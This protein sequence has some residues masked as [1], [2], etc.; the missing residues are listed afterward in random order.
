[1]FSTA[2][3]KVRT[4]LVFAKIAYTHETHMKDPNQ[5]MKVGTPY[6]KCPVIDVAGRQVNDSAI[7]FKNL[8]PAIGLPFNEEW[9]K[10]ITL[11]LD[12]SVKIQGQSEDWSKL[13]TATILNKGDAPF[14]S[15]LAFILVPNVV[16]PKMVKVESDQGKHNI[17]H[18]GCGHYEKPVG[19]FAK[20]FAAA[21]AGVFFGGDKP[22][23]PD[24]SLYG[25]LAG[26]LYAGAPIANTFIKAGGLEEWLEAMQK[27]VPLDSCFVKG[28]WKP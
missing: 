1:M 3:T 24:I 12:T 25:Y 10:K 28:G 19:E 20:E 2:T 17:A 7:I 14:P 26:F 8:L 9:E 22:A 15:C 6:Q 23:H 27:L 18:S 5:G 16:G 11:G 4:C 13:F 21:R